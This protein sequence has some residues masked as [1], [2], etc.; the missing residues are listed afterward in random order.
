MMVI[1]KI[2][3]WMISIFLV[4]SAPY[5]I[6]FNVVHF[7]SKFKCRKKHYNEYFNCC[8]EGDCKWSKFCENYR[9]ILTDDEV[10]KLIKMINDMS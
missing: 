7:C 3:S 8:H 2:I 10:A 6:Y 1:E 4:V 5:T 9:N